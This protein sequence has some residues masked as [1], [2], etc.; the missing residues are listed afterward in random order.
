MELEHLRIAAELFRRHDGRD[1]EQ[2]CAPESPPPVTFE[3]NTGYL[4]DLLATQLDY[5]TL[6]TGYG[7]E[8]HERLVRARQ[9]LFGGQQ[10]PSERV[11]Q[12]ARAATGQDR[13][14]ARR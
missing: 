3:P 5:T 1:P 9:T 2:V 11:V 7:R 14:G 6:G 4:R 8:P 12:D 10:A 13:L